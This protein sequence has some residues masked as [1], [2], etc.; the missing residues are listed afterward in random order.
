MTL[1]FLTHPRNSHSR[2]LRVVVGGLLVVLCGCANPSMQPPRTSWPMMAFTPPVVT[3]DRILVAVGSPSLVAE[4]EPQFRQSRSRLKVRPHVDAE[5]SRPSRSQIDFE[6]QRK[7]DEDLWHKTHARARESLPPHPQAPPAAVEPS[8]ALPAAVEH[9]QIPPAAVEHIQ[10][11]PVAVEHI[12]IPPVA[13]ETFV[14][15]DSPR[16]RFR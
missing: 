7:I 14:P 2:R 6:I 15:N 4:D 10:I 12:Q 8:Q 11:P 13:V 16:K 5:D 9:I 1:A 3:D